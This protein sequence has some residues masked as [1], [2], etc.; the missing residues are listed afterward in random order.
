MSDNAFL[1]IMTALLK[2]Q[3]KKM[4]GDEALGAIGEEIVAIGGENLD[5]KIYLLLSEKTTI[6]ALESAAKRANDSFLE[7]IDLL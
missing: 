5:E 3:V 7:K 1:K 6:E 2:H 4:I